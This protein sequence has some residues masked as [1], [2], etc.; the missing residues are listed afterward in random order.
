MDPKVLARIEHETKVVMFVLVGEQ[1]EASD[2]GQADRRALGLRT[3]VEYVGY[4]DRVSRGP[5][6]DVAAD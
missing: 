3:V 2:I 4:V 5:G 6:S 1:A